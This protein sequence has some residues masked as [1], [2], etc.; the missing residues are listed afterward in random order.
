MIE[1]TFALIKPDAFAQRE[2]IK[3]HAQV[4]SLTITAEIEFT[5]SV[6]QAVS[7]YRQHQGKPHFSP[8]IQFMT[9]GPC[10]AFLLMGENAVTSWRRIMGATN[11]ADAEAWTIRG[12][13]GNPN[14]I[15][16]NAVHGSDSSEEA[17]REANL[18]FGPMSTFQ[19]QL[20]RLTGK[21]DATTRNKA[22]WQAIYERIRR[23]EHFEP[24]YATITASS[25]AEEG[26]A[27]QLA[28]VVKLFG[29]KNACKILTDFQPS[30]P[31]L[32]TA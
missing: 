22:V 4:Y 13:Y 29:Y 12:I 1:T 24:G 15:R 6:E 20:P 26:E 31:M 27:A 10:V 18:F 8:L 7:L 32:V 2:E 30:H 16:E 23:G 19:E 3:L 21:Y 14:I 17:I 28:E 11:S 9:S 25:L 5:L